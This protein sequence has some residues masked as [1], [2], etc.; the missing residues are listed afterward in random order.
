MDQELQ[1][2]LSALRDGIDTIDDQILALLARRASLAK[3]VGELKQTSGWSYH[4]PERERQ[5]IERLKGLAHNTDFPE[6]A[7][8]S[9]YREVMSACLRLESPITVSYLGP[10]STFSF[11]ALRKIFGESA[12]AM[13]ERTIADVFDAIEQDRS[14]YS[15]VPI[16]NS[17]EGT[18]HESMQRLVRTSAF[19]HGEY[20]L[21]IVHSLASSAS[22]LRSIE[23][24]F[25]HPQAF[26]QCREWIRA[27]MPEAELVATN[28]TTQ[29]CEQAASAPGGAAIANAAA[30]AESGLRVL[31]RNIQDKDDNQ[32]RFLVL[33]RQRSLQPRT[34]DKTSLIF[35]VPHLSGKLYH[36]LE[37]F[38]RSQINIQKL[39]AVPDRQTPWKA[40]F[41]MD[42]DAILESDLQ[43]QVFA[44]A[45][46]YCDLFRH[47]GTYPCLE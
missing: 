9:V 41:W 31:A 18:V 28:S 6:W 20:Y 30:A 38:G 12:C 19:V 3:K 47:I 16:E 24:V 34:T 5:V 35:S 23:R 44:D 8:S 43:N 2:E 7:V 10:G 33:T 42:A 11:V 17:F 37:A 4:V 39:E 1:D 21:P 29:A 22:E 14:D 25:S 40:Y 46:R 27:H 36:V 13:P 32:T 15:V 26:M 45:R